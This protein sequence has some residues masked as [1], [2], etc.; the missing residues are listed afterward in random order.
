MLPLILLREGDVGDSSPAAALYARVTEQRNR[1]ER[2]FKGSPP[3]GAPPGGSWEVLRVP[4]RGFF[5]ACAFETE[6]ALY[7]VDEDASTERA[8]D[9]KGNE[10]AFSKGRLHWATNLYQLAGILCPCWS[11]PL[12]CVYAWQDGAN[13]CC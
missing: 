13:P 10:L 11:V 5:R 3:P 7:L 4:M 1:L 6:L 12:G 8:Y 9:A 2:R